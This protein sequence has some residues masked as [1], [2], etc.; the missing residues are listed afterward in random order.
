MRK[1]QQTS[2]MM[3]A[4]YA[5]LIC[6]M[7]ILAVAGARLYTAAMQ[8]KSSN[9]SSRNAL[10]VVQTQISAYGGQGCAQLRPGPEGTA[11]CLH[12]QGSDYE[13]RIYLYQGSLCTEYTRRDL[14][15]APQNAG[16]LCQLQSFEAAWQQENLICITANGQTAY[17]WCAGGGG[18]AE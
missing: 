5:I 14:D 7:L 3:L 6:A 13:T 12:Q 9:S 1:Q 17:A 18:N 8:S 16:Q 15:F 11:V 10:S 2:L 4:L